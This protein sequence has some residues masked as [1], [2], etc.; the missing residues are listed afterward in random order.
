MASLNGPTNQPT[1]SLHTISRYSRLK[2][3]L[4]SRLA[5]VVL[6]VTIPTIRVGLMMMMGTVLVFRQDICISRMPLDATIAGL[7]PAHVIQYWLSG[8]H[9]LTDPHVND[10]TTDHNAEGSDVQGHHL[11]QLPCLSLT[12][13]LTLTLTLTLTQNKTKQRCWLCFW[14]DDS[15]SSSFGGSDDDDGTVLDSARFVLCE[16]FGCSRLL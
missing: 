16:T 7:M 13:S 4:Y 15:T 1:A 10:S 6:Q 8:A 5:R 12:L 2:R 9:S 14:D 3:S 11:R